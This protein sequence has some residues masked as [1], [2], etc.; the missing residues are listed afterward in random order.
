[1]YM[2]ALEVAGLGNMIGVLG[3]VLRVLLVIVSGNLFASPSL[4]LVVKDF[5]P[6]NPVHGLLAAVNVMT[7]WALAVWALGLA[8]LSGA[9]YAKAAAWVFGIWAGLTGLMI[10]FAFAAQALGNRLGG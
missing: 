4:M 7:F 9:S 6:Q 5:D 10:G 1:S 3:A 2:K 8:R